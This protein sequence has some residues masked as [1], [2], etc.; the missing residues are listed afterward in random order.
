MDDW[1]VGQMSYRPTDVIYARLA[2]EDE[3]AAIDWLTKAFGFRER[4]RKA[5]PEGSVLAWLELEGGTVM[6]CRVGYGLQSPKKLGGVSHK[7]I[8]YV[9]D[10]DAHYERAK[11]AGA[12]IDREL[13]DTPWGDRRYEAIDP[14]GHPWHFAQIVGT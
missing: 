13:D 2:Y 12:V 3:I 7:M 9:E 4:D 6:V 5:N 11:A 1:E 8:C 10:V 14:E